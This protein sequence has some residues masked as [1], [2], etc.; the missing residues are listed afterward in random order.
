M[1]PSCSYHRHCCSITRNS[2]STSKCTKWRN[3]R[4]H[5]TP[6]IRQLNLEANETLLAGSARS[7]A[8]INPPQFRVS[9]VTVNGCQ[10][11]IVG[12]RES[13]PDS[14]MWPGEKTENSRENS[15]D[16]LIASLHR[17]PITSCRMKLALRLDKTKIAATID[18]RDGATYDH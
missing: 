3:A 7:P 4:S 14:D 11:R 17:E 15:S 6:C 12:P 18:R 1:S 16:P 13:G 5:G 10:C 2:P 9:S 8:H